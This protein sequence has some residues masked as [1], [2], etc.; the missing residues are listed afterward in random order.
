MEKRIIQVDQFLIEQSSENV[1]LYEIIDNNPKFISLRTEFYSSLETAILSL[2]N[3]L[4]TIRIQ[5]IVRA[6]QN[7]RELEKLA[8]LE[9]RKTNWEEF[10]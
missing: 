4:Q 8:K 6:T 7:I 1:F 5:A 10:R 3:K 9:F 2:Q